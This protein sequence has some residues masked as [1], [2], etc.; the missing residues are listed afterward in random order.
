MITTFF[1]GAF[2]AFAVEALRKDHPIAAPSIFGVFGG[3]VLVLSLILGFVGV[4]VVGIIIWILF[5][6]N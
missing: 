3:I 2:M 6:K 1:M 5:V 4:I